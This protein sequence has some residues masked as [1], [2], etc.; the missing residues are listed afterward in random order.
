MKSKY[1][2]IQVS[3][4]VLSKIIKRKASPSESAN[5]TINRI[6]ENKDISG[7]IVRRSI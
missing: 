6:I 1:T 2:T 5:D 4:K 3:R 7:N